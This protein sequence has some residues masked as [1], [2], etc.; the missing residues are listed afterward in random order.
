MK[1]ADDTQQMVALIKKYKPHEFA[2][3]SPF[4][5]KNVQSMLKLG[6]GTGCGD[7]GC[8]QRRL[9]GDRIFTEKNKTIHHRQWQC[10]QR[11]GMENA[12][13]HYLL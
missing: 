5:G 3:E 8:Y 12:A 1:A 11:T 13:A 10:R 7:C 4:F 6:T 2:I 9:T